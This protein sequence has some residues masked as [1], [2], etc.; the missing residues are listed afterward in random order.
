MTWVA[1]WCVCEPASPGYTMLTTQVARLG[2]SH[3]EHEPHTLPPD[4]EP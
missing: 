4:D 3:G 1:W 2:A